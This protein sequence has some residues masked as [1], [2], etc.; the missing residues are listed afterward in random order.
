MLH[1]VHQLVRNFFSLPLGAGQVVWWVYQSFWGQKQL[2][3]AAE[4]KADESGESESKH[5]DVSRKTK[6]MSRKTLK[7]KPAMGNCRGGR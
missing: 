1:Y 3:A 5:K 2:F 7:H 6:T 4:N